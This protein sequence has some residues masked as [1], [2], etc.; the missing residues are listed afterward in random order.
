[1]ELMEDI[2]SDLQSINDSVDKSGKG[3]YVQASTLGSLE[4]LLEFLKSSKIPVAGVGLGPIHKK[5]VTQASIMLEKAREFAVML[6]F[7]VKID[8]DAQEMAD[9][10]GLKVFTADIIYHLFDRFTEHNRLINEQKRKD[11]TPQAVF[12]CVLKMIKGAII[13]KRDPLILGV[14][15]AEGQ[16]RTGTPVCVVKTNPETK[17][18][19]VVSL[20][21]VVSM[22]INHKHMDIVRKGESGAGVAIRIECAAYESA[23]TYGRHF[24]DSDDIYSLISRNSIDVLKESFRKDLSK[25][26]WALVVKLKKV[27]NIS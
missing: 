2:M 3:V 17:A 1:E 5:H 21:K 7:D 14:D 11:L 12:P 15:V 25:D 19:E 10:L 22:E 13:N 18:R 27:L 26:E 23:K 16:L 9:E 24:D 20:G 6:C 4:A 8:K